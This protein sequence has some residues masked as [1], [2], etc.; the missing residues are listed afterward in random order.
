MKTPSGKKNSRQPSE[1]RR[2]GLP[3][4]PQSEETFP[5][6]TEP[7]GQAGLANEAR[8]GL[9]TRRDEPFPGE[10]RHTPPA[11][12]GEEA[13]DNVSRHQHSS[14]EPNDKPLPRD[15]REQ[16]PDSWN[17]EEERDTGASGHMG[18]G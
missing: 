4:S 9:G 14:R 10:P 13:E 18:A 2:A 12:S 11:D 15:P 5:H 8:P 1:E 6:R 16:M 3:E 17:H 7:P